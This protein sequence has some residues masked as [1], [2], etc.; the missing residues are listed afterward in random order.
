MRLIGELPNQAQTRKFCAFLLSE[1]IDTHT[2]GP[3]DGPF[4]IWVKDEDRFKFSLEEFGKFTEDPNAQRY[5]AAVAKAEKILRERLERQKQ[6]QKNMTK[7]DRATA[8]RNPRGSL[9]Q[10]GPLTTALLAICVL[11]GFLTELGSNKRVDGAIF[12]ALQFLAYENPGP[13]L[14]EQ[15][16]NNE[17]DYRV[18]M[19]SVLK[20]EFWRVFSPIFLHM[21]LPHILFNMLWLVQLGLLLEERYGTLRLAAIILLVAA[22]SNI[23]QC[24]VPIAWGGSVPFMDNDVLLTRL[25]GM[26]GVVYGLFG[27]IWMK[28]IYDPS[29]RLYLSQGTIF[30]MVGWLFFCMLTPNLGGLLGESARVAN[31]AH[32]VGLVSGMVLAFAPLPGSR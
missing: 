29:S 30:L 13:E 1:S 22:L 31:W 5:D 2:E 19:A 8:P 9:F 6:H 10:R 32:A 3:D 28:A 7:V 24:T 16:T 27:Y 18:R 14:L 26:S 23:A 17:E 15:F 21:S 11:V 12:R 4:E 25:G 20:G